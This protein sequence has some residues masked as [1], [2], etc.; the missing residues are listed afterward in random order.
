M[1]VGDAETERGD[2]DERADG[3]DRDRGGTSP[4]RCAMPRWDITAPA[5]RVSGGTSRTGA[6][7]PSTGGAASVGVW[8]CPWWDVGSGQYGGG[9]GQVEVVAVVVADDG[10]GADVE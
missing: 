9:V 10:V 2:D 3:E 5:S 7:C 1:A 6:V 8:V 4:R